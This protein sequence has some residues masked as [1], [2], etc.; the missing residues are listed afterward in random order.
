MRDPYTAGHERRV[1]EIERGRDTLYD[2]AV[3]DACLRLVR[4]K[5]Y[6]IAA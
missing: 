3:V 1:A 4:V 5:G 2:A 6:T